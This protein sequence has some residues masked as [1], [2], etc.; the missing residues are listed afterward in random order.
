M[1]IPNWELNNLTQ[2]ELFPWKWVDDESADGLYCSLKK[3]HEP[4][5]IRLHREIERRRDLRAAE[6]AQTKADEK[7]V[8]GDLT[9]TELCRANLKKYRRPRNDFWA[10]QI[11]FNPFMYIN[12][13]TG[14][15]MYKWGQPELDLK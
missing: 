7:L 14:E 15:P 10:R 9:P 3:H 5:V 11:V 1:K 6:E 4:F 8:A 12:P 2:P 13:A